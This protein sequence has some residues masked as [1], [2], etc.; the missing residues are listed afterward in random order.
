[1]IVSPLKDPINYYCV[2]LLKTKI[3]I[4]CLLL[5]VF[6]AIYASLLTL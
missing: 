3:Q 2:L 5:L 4:M 6:A 1:M